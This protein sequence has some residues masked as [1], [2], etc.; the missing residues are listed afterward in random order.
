MRP[1]IVA[2]P[3]LL[4]IDD[5]TNLLRFFEYNIRG[6]GFDVATGESGADF[7]RLIEQREYSTILLDVMLPDTNGIELMEEAHRLYPDLPVI[8]ITAYGTIEKAVEAMKRGAMDFLPKPVD[9]DRLNSIIVNAVRQYELRREVKT[10]RRQIEPLKEF[11]G[12]V[13]QS[14]QMLEIYD[15]IERV[16]PTSATVMI[17]GES[18]TGKELVAKAIHSLSGRSQKPFVAINC[19][20][21]SRDL[22]ESELFG[23]ERGSFTGAEARH[24]GC[25]ER[26]D[27]G[28]LFLDEICEMDLGL[29]AKLLRV[30]QERMFYRVGGS[31]PIEVDVRLVAATNQNPTEAVAAGRFRE[32][33]YYRLNVVPIPLPALRDRAEDI[34][35]IA[36]QFLREFSEQNKRSFHGFELEALGAMERYRWGG[37]VR[38]LRNVI[39]QIVVLNDGERVSP[40]M[41]PEAIQSAAPAPSQEASTASGRPASL[42]AAPVVE[43]P[44][45]IRP[46]WQVERDTIQRA[47]DLCRGNVQDVARRLS[48]SPATLYRKIEKYGLVK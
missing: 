5:E 18:G 34:G 29:Q 30:I 38:E 33:L 44:A 8:L 6:L 11:Q 46:F 12:M 47:L 39:E 20:A 25:F 42:S 4:V 28:T 2:K 1:P 19:A 23:H 40:T 21:I 14:A 27:G 41:L 7:R 10:L 31:K 43:T 16:A 22:L 26:A 37:N 48:L 36:R 32:D 15:T 45:S 9:I 3:S 17:T 13:G 24:Q 35:Q